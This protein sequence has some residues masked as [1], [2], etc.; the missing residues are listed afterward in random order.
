MLPYKVSVVTSKSLLSFFVNTPRALIIIPE[1][2]I[3]TQQK[4]LVGIEHQISRN[5][6]FKNSQLVGS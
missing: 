1:P 4:P 2:N 5:I 6:N 3:K